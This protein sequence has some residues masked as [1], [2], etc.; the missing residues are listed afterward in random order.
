[1]ILEDALKL[2]QINI[3]QRMGGVRS[4]GEATTRLENL[5]KSVRKE[6][7]R[8]AKELHPDINGSHEKMVELNTAMQLIGMMHV[9]PPRPQP[10]VIVYRQSYPSY[11]NGTST[12]STCT[13]SW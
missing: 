1:M 13:F 7:R 3:S 11:S 10:V 8:K 4:F 2:F 6:Y 5:K 12:A 9:E